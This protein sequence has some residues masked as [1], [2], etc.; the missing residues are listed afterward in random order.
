[1]CPE[2][3][4]K[5]IGRGAAYIYIEGI[6]SL[7]SGYIF[8]LVVSNLTTSEI[9]G[10]SSTLIT[11]ATI[12]A[13]I[14]GMGIHVGIQRFIG[15]SFS[16][17]NIPEAKNFV[18][19][20]LLLLGIG[21]FSCSMIILSVQNS[22]YNAFGFDL[23]LLI[24][25]IL[26]IASYNSMMIFR[27]IVISS[28]KTQSL[29]LIFITSSVAKIII[30][31]FLLIA[32]TG[33]VGLT[34]GFIINYILSSVLLGIV[35]LRSIF[36]Q[37]KNIYQLSS[38]LDNSKK[39]LV[40][41]VVNWIPWLITIVGSQLGTIVI[42]GAQGANQAGVYFLA[43]TIVTGITT[44]MNSLFTI[45]LPALSSLR[46]HRKRIAWQ[47]IRLSTIIILPFSCSLIFYS[48]DV[49]R[50]FGDEY[51]NGAISLQ[52][53][54]LSILPVCVISGVTTLLN[55]YGYY[56]YVLILGLAMS[57]PQ[58]ILYF[59]LVPLY[60]TIGAALGYTIGCVAGCIVSL[61]QARKIGLHLH[62]KELG[63]IFIVSASIGY[64]LS[65][66]QINYI[67]GIITTIIL[68]YVLLIQVRVVTTN[69]IIDFLDVLPD[70]I[71]NPVVRLVSKYKKR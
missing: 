8:W 69:D 51:V 20:S 32:G 63:I 26:L 46:D 60:D 53:L 5:A 47:A 6:T 10:T 24:I 70:K 16:E 28:L 40:S 57:I 33:V 55:S 71:S 31:I 37:A 59:T 1:M 44:I 12:I 15:K 64:I 42:F 13:V 66:L 68:S 23:V 30:T 3:E 43:L 25:A 22:I 52:I 4:K 27:S 36:K 17:K 61:L 49:M 39:I 18:I 58:T 54:L 14:A 11:F 41:S 9:I 19:I 65:S 34:F 21:I 29:P 7:V 35:L 62:W 48:N 56:R 2:I 67:L 45:A 50:L 38:F